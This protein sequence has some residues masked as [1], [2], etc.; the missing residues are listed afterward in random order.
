[1]RTRKASRLTRWHISWI[2]CI[3]RK[4]STRTYTSCWSW[5]SSVSTLQTDFEETTMLQDVHSSNWKLYQHQIALSWLLLNI[6]FDHMIFTCRPLP[7][8]I[9][10]ISKAWTD[11]LTDQQSDI[12]DLI[13]P[14][15][16]DLADV[17]GDLLCSLSEFLRFITT[18]C[19]TH[20]VRRQFSIVLN[21]R[22][23]AFK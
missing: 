6:Y 8:A 11:Q 18:T 3:K 16:V 10:G 1:V 12:L 13:D 14:G 17:H 21:C 20:V 22:S 23:T 4:H 2:F 7:G 9:T 19:F 5:F 15:D